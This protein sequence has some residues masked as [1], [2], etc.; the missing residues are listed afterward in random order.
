MIRNKTQV[1]VSGMILLAT[2]LLN[3]I[4]LQTAYTRNIT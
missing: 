1:P 3:A 4:I 2:L